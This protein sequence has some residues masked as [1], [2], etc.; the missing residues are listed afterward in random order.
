VDTYGC[1]RKEISMSEAHE[2]ESHTDWSDA[3]RGK[4]GRVAIADMERVI[5]AALTSLTGED[6]HA[7]VEQIEFTGPR[8]DA[9]MRLKN[10]RRLEWPRHKSGEGNS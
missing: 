8:R 2:D 7:E 4:L 1:G 3:L 5:A 9:K 6:Y 10:S